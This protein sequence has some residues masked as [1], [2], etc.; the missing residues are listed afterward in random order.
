MKQTNLTV[1]NLAVCLFQG[2]DEQTPAVDCW[3]HQWI[4][5]KLV[6]F[7]PFLFSDGSVSV[8]ELESL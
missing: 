6:Y 2:K 7:I 8:A 3:Q 5:L 1:N 4:F